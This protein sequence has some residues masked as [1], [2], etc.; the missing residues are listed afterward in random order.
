MKLVSAALLATVVAASPVYAANIVY[1][2]PMLWAGGPANGVGAMWTTEFSAAQNYGFR[3]FDDFTLSA[4][5]SITG[6]RWYAATFDY[7]NTGNN[8]VGLNGVT[9]YDIAFYSDN[10][11]LPGAQVASES[12]GAAA[13]TTTLL[14]T[15]LFSG[16]P[17]N[18]YEFS[19][20][21][22]TPVNLN[23]GTPYWF[24]PLVETS[25]FTPE[26]IAWIHGTNGNN[27][28][29]QIGLGT[30]TGNGV[31]NSDR[32]FAL[33]PEPATF[34]LLTVGLVGLR[35]LRRRGPVVRD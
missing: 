33:V 34:A 5:T 35:G 3:T 8:P 30:A 7:I 14:G 13:V 1:N 25:M 20:T 22:A 12:V 6:V 16:S 4:A 9:G 23:A 17:V 2:Q 11:G 26:I 28:S 21:F 32:A 15:G 29:Y 10:A 31:L 24:S 19:Y 18:V 27:R